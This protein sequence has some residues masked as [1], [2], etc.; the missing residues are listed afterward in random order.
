VVWGGTLSHLRK[1]P[2]TGD[3]KKDT[4][5]LAG[6]TLRLSSTLFKQLSIGEWLVILVD[7]ILPFL[8]WM[9]CVPSTLTVDSS[10]KVVEHNNV[11]AN[12]LFD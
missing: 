8:G 7:Q 6:G 10:R 12:D 2:A 1:G 11:T 3:E 9:F 5:R 4:L